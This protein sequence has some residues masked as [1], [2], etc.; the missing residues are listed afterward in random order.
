MPRLKE[1]TKLSQRLLA[2]NIFVLAIGRTQQKDLLKA[3]LQGPGCLR[4]GRGRKAGNS[5]G[6]KDNTREV[7]KSQLGGLCCAGGRGENPSEYGTCLSCGVEGQPEN[8]A[9]FWDPEGACKKSEAMGQ[10]FL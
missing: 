7:L 5:P 1:V 2:W 10:C 9:G 3:V 6:K 8:W 4:T